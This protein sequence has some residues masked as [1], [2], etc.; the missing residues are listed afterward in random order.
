MKITDIK[1]NPKNPRF[2]KDEKFKKLCD[3]IREFPKMME[4]RP[5]I[6]DN[7]NI[8]IGG[9]MRYRALK[10]LGYKE[11]PDNWVKQADQLTEDEKK[12]FVIQ[13]N[14]PGGDWD[15]DELANSWDSELLSDWGMDINYFPDVVDGEFDNAKDRGDIYGGNSMPVRIGS[16][17]CYIIDQQ[18]MNKIY[19]ITDG[20]NNKLGD[21]K[22]AQLKRNEIGTRIC[23]IILE[24]E[25]T[26]LGY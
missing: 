19:E 4:L 1:I 25:T 13:D 7:E 8:I 26:L 14:I 18:L 23:D 3:S 6:Y 17:I 12:R 2:I 9:N 21:G 5:I 24:N 16:L 22:E 15:W 20:I 11:I 10:E